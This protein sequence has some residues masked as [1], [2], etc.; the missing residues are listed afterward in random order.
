MVLKTPNR[1][2]DA[3]DDRVAAR[4]MIAAASLLVLAAATTVDPL[5]EFLSAL[6]PSARQKALIRFTDEERFD[7]HYVPRS[8]RGVPLG[9]LN[10]HQTS[11]LHSFL[12]A[13]LGPAGYQK[14]AG[15]I[16]LES[17]LGRLEGSWSRNPARYYFSLFG[18]PAARPWSWRFEG[19]HLSLNVAQ[20]ARG[21]SYTPMFIGANPA[22]VPSGARAGWELLRDEEHR[23]RAFLQSL[24]AAQRA[25]AIISARA[26]SDIVTGT[27]RSFRLQSFEGLPGSAMTE[28]QRQ[29]LLELVLVYVRNAP[30][31]AADAEI[32]KIR[33]AGIEKLHFAWAGGAQP[34]QPHY[35]RIH[36]P[37]V[38]IEY[39]NTYGNH[40]H[41][42]WRNPHGDF[43]DDVLARHYAEAP[44]H[45]AT[46][47]HAH[48]H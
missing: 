27:D 43:G 8:R 30:Q 1:L 9:D 28:R 10:R 29:A 18:D 34:R 45:A 6:S 23:G 20:T 13:N 4:S 5:R 31:P 21:T 35:Y 14:A 38:L 19:H 16:E 44:H 39:D 15:V 37:T 32:G 47:G 25:Q 2:R 22:R 40:I 7:W 36:G 41:T 26:P 33:R 17:I 3:P 12:R 46:A 42:V 48:V 11:L 24:D